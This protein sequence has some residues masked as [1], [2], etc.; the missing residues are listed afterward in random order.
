MRINETVGNFLYLYRRK[1]YLTLEQIS[2][3]SQRYGSGWSGATIGSMERGGS[4]AD[5]LAN[6]LILLSSLNDLAEEGYGAG[7]LTLSSIF[8]YSGGV[9]ITDNLLVPE[10]D[11]VSILDGSEVA[12]PSGYREAARE[13]DVFYSEHAKYEHIS[14]DGYEEM[15]VSAGGRGPTSAEKRVADKLGWASLKVAAICQ[16]MYGHSLDEEASNRAGVGASPQ[17]RGRATRSITNEIKDYAK[18]TK[19]TK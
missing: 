6:I 16:I 15:R 8:K 12:L 2:D 14:G 3:A 10:E 9:D 13:R 19:R 11:I 17:K 1:N 5:S 4:R 7:G 18:R